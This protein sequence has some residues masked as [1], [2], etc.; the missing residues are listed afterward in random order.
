[1]QQPNRA[2]GVTGGQ[3]HL[4]EIIAKAAVAIGVDGLFLETHPNPKEAKSDGENMLPLDQ[5]EDLLIKLI[6]IR[7]AIR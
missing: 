6:K 1:L 4:I 7:A 2:S 5:V 3:P